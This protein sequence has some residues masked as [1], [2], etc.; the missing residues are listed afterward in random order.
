[1]GR[2]VSARQRPTSRKKAFVFGRLERVCEEGMKFSP[3]AQE[4]AVR[5]FAAGLIGINIQAP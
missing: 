1:M 2:Q 4:D 3:L 5:R